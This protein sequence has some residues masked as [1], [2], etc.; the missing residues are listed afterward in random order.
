MIA[1][2]PGFSGFS[3]FYP[4]VLAGSEAIVAPS[5]MQYMISDVVNSHPEL[6]KNAPKPLLT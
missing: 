4:I 6:F 1:K 2:F 5:Q 3:S